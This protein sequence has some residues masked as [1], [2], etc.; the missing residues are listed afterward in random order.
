MKKQKKKTFSSFEDLGG[1]VYS[2]DSETNEQIRELKRR[3]TVIEA[4]FSKKGRGGKTA[5]VLKGFRAGDEE[6]KTLAKKIK[7]ALGVGG[8][9]KNGEIIIQGNNRDKIIDFLE[10]E[11]YKVKKVGG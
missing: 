8:S 1:L 3:N 2:T 7:S 6:L 10:K 5:T 11:G 9:A 4:R